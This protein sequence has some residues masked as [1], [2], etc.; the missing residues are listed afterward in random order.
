VHEGGWSVE[1]WGEGRPAFFDPRG[2]THFEG[3]WK[4]DAIPDDVIEALERENRRRGAEP[5][6]HTASARWKRIEDVPDDVLFG[7]LEAMG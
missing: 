4:P 2:G 1:W 5:D 7:A 3:R 6:W